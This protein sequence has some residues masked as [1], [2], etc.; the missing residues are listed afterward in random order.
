MASGSNLVPIVPRLQGEIIA[1]TIV[2]L[3][4]LLVVGLRLLGRVR[5]IGLGWDDGLVVVATVSCH[6]NLAV[7]FWSLNNSVAYVHLVASYGRRLWVFFATQIRIDLTINLIGA[8]LGEGHNLVPT[9]PYFQQGTRWIASY[10]AILFRSRR[11]LW[12]RL[13]ELTSISMQKLW[14][15]FLK[16]LG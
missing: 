8:T 3:I 11:S 7:R 10:M 4:V 15:M 6:L 9:E 12:F 2:T 14:Q 1:H 16:F 13:S 5:G